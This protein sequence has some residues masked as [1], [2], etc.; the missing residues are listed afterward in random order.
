MAKK[1]PPLA[2]YGGNDSGNP[3][4][5]SKD[6]ELIQ[7]LAAHVKPGQEITAYSLPGNEAGDK[8]NMKFGFHAEDPKFRLLGRDQHAK[9]KTAANQIIANAVPEWGFYK[10]DELAA[11]S[12]YKRTPEIKEREAAIVQAKADIEREL[13]GLE[14]AREQAVKEVDQAG[15]N[16]HLRNQAQR[17]LDF[18]DKQ[19]KDLKNGPHKAELALKREIEKEVWNAATI[20]GADVH[21]AAK[22]NFLVNEGI[23]ESTKAINTDIANNLDDLI[24]NAPALK[25]QIQQGQLT[26][27]QIAADVKGAIQMAQ[28]PSVQVSQQPS[29]ADAQTSVSVR[30]QLQQ[31]TGHKADGESVSVDKKQTA[32]EAK[33]SVRDQLRAQRADKLETDA[34]EKKVSKSVSIS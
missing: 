14:K 9:E 3:S 2:I 26:P 7:Q 5:L 11:K 20:T 27:Q 15:T 8:K 6:S 17:K 31:P 22:V 10:R 18:I 24:S 33:E 1:D 32:K 13:P 25:A 12:E 4:M 34:P 16:L 30:D 29:G 28:Q 21:Q 19:I 23:L